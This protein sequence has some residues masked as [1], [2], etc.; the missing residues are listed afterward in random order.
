MELILA[1][2]KSGKLWDSRQESQDT[3]KHDKAEKP[4]LTKEA[5]Q[6][7]THETSA[8]STSKGVYTD[9]P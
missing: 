2:G 9:K 1:I 5:E 7:E 3:T 8:S 4:D 6:L